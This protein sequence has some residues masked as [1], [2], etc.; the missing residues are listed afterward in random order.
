VHRVQATADPE[1]YLGG[2]QEQARVF[3]VVVAACDWS[4]SPGSKCGGNRL[5]Y[6]GRDAGVGLEFVSRCGAA[7]ARDV[8][9]SDW[10]RGNL[11]MRLGVLR[12][13][14]HV[15]GTR[16]WRGVLRIFFYLFFFSGRRLELPAPVQ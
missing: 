10:R 13:A 6:V 1:P 16:E 5:L 14:E 2:I 11:G 8:A 9:S 12:P 7:Q 15:N 3:D 4:S